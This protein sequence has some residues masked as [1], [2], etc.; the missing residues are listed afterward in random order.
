MGNTFLELLSRQYEVKQKDIGQ[1]RQFRMKGLS[2]QVEACQA[3]GF[4]H[5]CVMEAR[6]PLGLMVMTS[7]VLVPDE[8]D[9]PLFSADRMKMLGNDVL[10][11]EGYQ[12]QLQ[13][14]VLSHLAQVKAGCR[15]LQDY[16]AEPRW[17]DS[18]RI[19]EAFFKKGKRSAPARLDAVMA[20]SLEAFLQ[21]CG[22]APSCDV[23]RK[24]EKNAAF[25]DTMV[26]Q[27]GVSTDLFIK[28]W[29]PEKA[30]TFL[31]RVVF[32]TEV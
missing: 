19:P 5:V 29:G 4:G 8:I 26:A 17:Y 30:G 32:G 15:D 31:R 10:L 13:P 21:D 27:G 25:V 12:T 16:A 22:Q 23:Q 9:M 2:F 24:R 11:I 20:Q 3:E 7:Y 1:F 14:G 28:S 18:H 6:A